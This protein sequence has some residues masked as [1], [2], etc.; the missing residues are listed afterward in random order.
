MTVLVR[1]SKTKSL[2][3]CNPCSYESDLRAIT[4]FEGFQIKVWPYIAHV[5]RKKSD[6]LK[7]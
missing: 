5:E 3:I 4:D 7:K 6:F 2:F 1:E